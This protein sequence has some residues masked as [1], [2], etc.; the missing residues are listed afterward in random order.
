MTRSST[1]ENTVWWENNGAMTPAHFAALYDDMLAYLQ[2]RDVYVEDLVGG[3]DPALSV[4][5][6][7]ITELAWHSL[8]NRTM[9]RRPER[10]ALD[11]SPPI[12][13]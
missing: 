5:M 8:F 11:I 10:A 6:R 7:M 13:R 3:A 9:L 2:G 1:T 12:S 4:N